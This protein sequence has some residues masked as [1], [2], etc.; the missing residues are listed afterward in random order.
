M[1]YAARNGSTAGSATEGDKRGEITG[2]TVM[3]RYDRF[4]D[5]RSALPAE[6]ARRYDS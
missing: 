5:I 1:F 6:A 4:V 2:S 3:C